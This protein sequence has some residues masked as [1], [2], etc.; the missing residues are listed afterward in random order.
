VIG[1]INDRQTTIASAVEE[2]TATTNEIGRTISEVA[3]GSKSI[4]VSIT[5]VAEAAAQTTGDAATTQQT[6]E[7]LART[8]TEL[9]EIVARFSAA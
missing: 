8:T 4:A 1:R 7:E 9:R 5:G 3:G 6:A 2:Q